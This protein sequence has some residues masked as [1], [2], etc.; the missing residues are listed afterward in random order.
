VALESPHG[1]RFLKGMGGEKF[2]RIWPPT[3]PIVFSPENPELTYTP[4]SFS[5]Q[6]VSESNCGARLQARLCS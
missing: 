2:L 5:L 6:G 1:F 4:A 3:E